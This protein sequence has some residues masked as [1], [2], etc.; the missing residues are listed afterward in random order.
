LRKADGYFIQVGWDDREAAA[1]PGQPDLLLAMALVLATSGTAGLADTEID[2]LIK[3]LPTQTDR[4]RWATART[5][6]P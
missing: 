4:D 3:A 2:K 6:G 5:D 1:K